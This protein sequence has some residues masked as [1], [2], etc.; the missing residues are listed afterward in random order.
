[1]DDD[2]R[3]RRFSEGLSR[4]LTRFV[5]D[6]SLTWTERLIAQSTLLSLHTTAED[7]GIDEQWKKRTRRL[8]ASADAGTESATG[9]QSVMNMAGHVLNQC[10]LKE[11]SIKLFRAEIDRSPWPTYFM[12]YVAETVDGVG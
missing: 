6:D 8:V 1:M 12:P 7:I 10:G 11:E 4:I 2:A 3:R 5:E 9:R